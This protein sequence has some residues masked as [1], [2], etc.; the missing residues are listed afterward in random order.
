MGS[1]SPAEFSYFAIRICNLWICEMIPQWMLHFANSHVPSQSV[2][3]I[4]ILLNS[5]VINCTNISQCQECLWQGR[6]Q[7]TTVVYYCG[8]GYSVQWGTV[9]RVQCSVYSGVQ[10]TIGYRLQST[11]GYSLKRVWCTY[12]A[13]TVC[14]LVSAVPS[15]KMGIM[16]IELIVRWGTYSVHCTLYNWPCSDYLLYTF[17]KSH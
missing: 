10:W 1:R 4:K 15:V 12:S 5:A 11:V 13:G 6:G 8:V 7:C 3:I 17:S 14:T 16:C 9:Y 2:V